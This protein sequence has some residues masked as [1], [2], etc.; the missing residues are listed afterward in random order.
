[1]DLCLDGFVWLV[2]V[3]SRAGVGW[4]GSARMLENP[5]PTFPPSQKKKNK[6]RNCFH[7]TPVTLTR[8]ISSA[9]LVSSSTIRP[10]TR[11]LTRLSSSLA[12]IPPSAASRYCHCISILSFVLHQYPPSSVSRT[13]VIRYP[14]RSLSP[15]TG[16]VLIHPFLSCFFSPFH[17]IQ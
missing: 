4:P 5:P 6:N 16:L 15:L 8:P 2:N 14:N 9:P 17:P 7:L 11:H 1:L 3:F 12:F 13:I 10:C